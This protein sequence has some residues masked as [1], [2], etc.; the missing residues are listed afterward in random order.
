MSG[1]VACKCD[2]TLSNTGIGCV[3]IW[4]TAR[5]VIFLPAYNDAGT[6]NGIPY[7]TTLNA[8]Y[9]TARINDPD[10]SARWYPLPTGKNTEDKRDKSTF[11]PMDDQS[12]A[13][14]QQAIRKFMI[15]IT[16]LDGQGASSPQM[17]AAIL[18]AR[19]LNL[20]VLIVDA[21]NNL[22][23]SNSDDGLSLNGI[24]A[25]AQSID[26]ILVNSS[27][28]DSNTQKIDLSFNFSQSENDSNLKMISCAEV[29]GVNLLNLSGL[30]NVCSK[31]TNITQT[32]FDI[33]LITEFGT[34][35]TPVLAK[36]LVKADFTKLRNDTDSADII[37]TTVTEKTAKGNYSVVIPSQ[38]LGDSM[39][40]TINKNG[41]DF[42]CVFDN[43]IVVPT[44]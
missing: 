12:T 8:A 9:F 7:G 14:I 15:E 37:I 28:K 38:T 16:S 19:C 17:I 21:E 29:G 31:I 44:S 11:E 2:N 42:T 39:S 36:G 1:C 26:A 5:K 24:L 34:P 6:R 10:A 3:P 33:E 32:G 30:K 25:D 43:K 27:L 22:K 35:I 13:F 4:A 23:G 20:S 41:Y 40:L 18:S